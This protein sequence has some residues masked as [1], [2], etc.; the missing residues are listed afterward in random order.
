MLRKVRVRDMLEEAMSRTDTD[1]LPNQQSNGL[2]M[3]TCNQRWEEVDQAASP[4]GSGM[5]LSLHP[6]L[7][8]TGESLE[9]AD[10]LTR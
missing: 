8:H 5:F 1:H 6:W 7:V 3:Y 10:W 4:L 2:T 9:E